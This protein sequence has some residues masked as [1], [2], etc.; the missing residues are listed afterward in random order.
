MFYFPGIPP[1]LNIVV[2]A[3][4]R[5]LLNKELLLTY[6]VE[7]PGELTAD[8]VNV[9]QVVLSKSEVVYSFL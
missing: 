7:N 6:L 1:L 9:N 8:C 4:V 2:H 3:K 5:Y